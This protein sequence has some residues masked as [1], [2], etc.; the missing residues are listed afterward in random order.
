MVRVGRDLARVAG[1]NS[2]S[3][4]TDHDDS[5]S[6]NDPAMLPH[7]VS[8]RSA[9]PLKPKAFDNRLVASRYGD[10]HPPKRRRASGWVREITH[11]KR[12]YFA[13]VGATTRSFEPR[14]WT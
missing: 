7:V 4:L 13:N 3:F 10:F 14:V 9:V 12:D 6:V 5:A 2:H 1:L 11:G 8:V